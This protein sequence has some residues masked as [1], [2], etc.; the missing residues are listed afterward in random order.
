MEV[1]SQGK[2]VVLVYPVISN[3]CCILCLMDFDLDGS[4]N[5]FP[6]A[7]V[8][9]VSMCALDAPCLIDSICVYI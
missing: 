8:Y 4:F 5:I 2:Q 1:Y 3:S 6:K 7:F 9:D